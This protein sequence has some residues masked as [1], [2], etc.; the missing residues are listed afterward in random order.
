MKKYKAFINREI[1]HVALTWEHPREADGEW[2]PLQNRRLLTEEYIA[3]ELREGDAKTREEVEE[4]FMPD[5]SLVPPGR[6]GLQAYETT[7]EGTPISPVFPDT[8]EGRYQLVA[9]CARHAT[10]FADIPATLQEWAKMLF[11]REIAAVDIQTGRIT[12]LDEER[13]LAGEKD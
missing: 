6:M 4:R 2:V 1:R 10:V 3:E 11:G 12:L 9:Y 13:T 5:F 7:S 8:P